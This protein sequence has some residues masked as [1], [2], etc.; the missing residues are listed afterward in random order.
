LFATAGRDRVIAV[1]N[2]TSGLLVRKFTTPVAAVNGLAFFPGDQMLASASADGSIYLWNV[3]SPEPIARL[4]S[5]NSSIVSMLLA[6]D[7]ETLISADTSGEIKYW[8]FSALIWTRLPF[9]PGHQLPMEQLQARVKK[10]DLSV[11]EKHW[12][13]FTNAL[14]Q[15]SR[16]FDIEVSEPVTIRLGEFDIEL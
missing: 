15:W 2:A 8:N 13:E 12:L 10:S 4:S 11:S 1:W 9:Q 3:S 6:A 14:W 5:H 16:R 7:G